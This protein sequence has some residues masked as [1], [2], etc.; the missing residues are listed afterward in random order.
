MKAVG[1]QKTRS[2]FKSFLFGRVCL[3]SIFDWA[4]GLL[5]HVSCLAF[6]RQATGSY[7]P[8][9]SSRTGDARMFSSLEIQTISF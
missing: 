1:R 8:K 2:E 9:G 7:H 6:R 4:L 5:A 3:L